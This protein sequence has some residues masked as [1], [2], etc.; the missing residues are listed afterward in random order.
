MR[1][2]TVD[3][4]HRSYSKP[5]DADASAW[6]QFS[7]S[8]RKHAPEVFR[9]LWKEIRPV[10]EDVQRKMGEAFVMNSFTLAALNAESDNLNNGAAEPLTNAIHK[11]CEKYSLNAPGMDEMVYG[12]VHNYYNPSGRLADF[13]PSYELESVGVPPEDTEFSFT[14]RSRDSLFRSDPESPALVSLVHSNEKALRQS[15]TK[16]FQ[17]ALDEFFERQETILRANGYQKIKTYRLPKEEE[18][19]QKKKNKHNIFDL[20]V[21]HQFKGMTYRVIA[22]EKLGKRFGCEET[23]RTGVRKARKLLRLKPPSRDRG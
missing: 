13:C 1:E 14:Y 16:E 18:D 2:E 8:I 19:K 5:G 23:V 4:S 17:V 22:R 15:I 12:F 20:L 7:V 9:N 10:Y 6:R 11:W 21:F 3:H